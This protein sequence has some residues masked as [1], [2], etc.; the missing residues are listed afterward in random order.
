MVHGHFSACRPYRHTLRIP[1][2]NARAYTGT[3]HGKEP[4]CIQTHRTVLNPDPQ[5]LL[6]HGFTPL[7]DEEFDQTQ[8]V[9]EKASRI[10]VWR[11]QESA[12]EG[13]A[14]PRMGRREVVAGE[15]GSSSARDAV[16][17]PRDRRVAPARLTSLRRLLR[18]ALLVVS[19][20]ASRRPCLF[21]PASPTQ[22]VAMFLPT[23]VSCDILY[24]FISSSGSPL[25]RR[26]ATT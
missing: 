11:Y 14:S 4:Y 25:A 16:S 23:L 8:S 2:H 22:G 20:L 26:P 12:K 18:L 9:V 19:R 6:F 15:R 21:A 1:P 17:T 13:S 7:R 5:P 24:R 10:G 3:R